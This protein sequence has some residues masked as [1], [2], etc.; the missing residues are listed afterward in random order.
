MPVVRR[1]DDNGVQIGPCQHISEITV[2]SASFILA[3]L[4]LIG[5]CLL[6][7]VERVLHFAGIDVADGNDLDGG[8]FEKV[9]Q[10]ARGHSASADDTDR[11]AVVG[12]RGQN[13][14][15][16]N[17]GRRGSGGSESFQE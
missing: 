8:H 16:G 15:H 9:S 14:W 7:Q 10:M 12:R 1:A 11:D 4:L 17:E 2:F 5:I 3:G 13:F 6:R